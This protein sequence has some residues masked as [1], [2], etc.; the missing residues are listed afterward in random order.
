M[1]LWA[2]LGFSFV[3]PSGAYKLSPVSIVSTLATSLEDSFYIL[4]L[5]FYTILS[6]LTVSSAVLINVSQCWRFP[7]LQSSSSKLPAK[8]LA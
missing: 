8:M 4:P 6:T 3:K 5:G 7:K 2:P 1:H